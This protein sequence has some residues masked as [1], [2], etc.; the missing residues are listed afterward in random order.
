MAS[1]QGM[2]DVS[3]ARDSID[4]GWRDDKSPTRF[5][6]PSCVSSCIACVHACLCVPVNSCKPRVPSY[7]CPVING[8]RPHS[9]G[10]RPLQFI[11]FKLPLSN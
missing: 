11:L 7:L 5:V 6:T 10:N 1:S 9:Y 3:K 8:E 4:K 2:S